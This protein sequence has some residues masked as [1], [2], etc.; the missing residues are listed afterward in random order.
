MDRLA[1]DIGHSVLDLTVLES[2]HSVHEPWRPLFFSYRIAQSHLARLC[3]R[4]RREV[5]PN[6]DT[7]LM[8]CERPTEGSLRPKRLSGL[9]S[10]VDGP[11]EIVQ[12]LKIAAE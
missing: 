3:G 4:G 8:T 6:G 7:A 5:E 2:G 10:R 12:F 9:I 1:P 11:V